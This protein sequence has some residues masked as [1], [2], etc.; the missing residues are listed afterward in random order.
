MMAMVVMV[1]V[2]IVNFSIV[3]KFCKNEEEKLNELVI[4]RA[5]LKV[6]L[7]AL[8]LVKLISENVKPN[9]TSWTLYRPIEEELKNAAFD[10]VKFGQKI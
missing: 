3:I 10:K 2:G 7:F 6:R 5:S 9:E 8:V 4:S 1:M